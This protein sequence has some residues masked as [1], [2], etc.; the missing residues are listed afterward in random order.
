MTKKAL[1]GTKLKNSGQE[2][3]SGK[4]VSNDA[5][6]VF[7]IECDSAPYFVCK[8]SPHQTPKGLFQSFRAFVKVTVQPQ[9]IFGYNP[10]L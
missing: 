4:V 9:C 2:T 3:R 1:Q 5:E 10:N 7:H 6:F 8:V